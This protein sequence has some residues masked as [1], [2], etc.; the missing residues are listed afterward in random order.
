MDTQI[1]KSEPTTPMPEGITTHCEI[2][3]DGSITWRVRDEGKKEPKH[4]P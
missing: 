3:D 2:S 4:G 1:I